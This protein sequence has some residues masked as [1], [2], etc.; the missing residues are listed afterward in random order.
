M[1]TITMVTHSPSQPG[2]WAV[3][4]CGRTAEERRLPPPGGPA[5]PWREGRWC[6]SH[7]WGTLREG[8]ERERE[9]GYARLWFVE[10]LGTCGDTL[11]WLLFTG[12]FYWRFSDYYHV[13]GI[14]FCYFHSWVR[15]PK[16]QLYCWED[17]KLERLRVQNFAFLCQSANIQNICTH[18]N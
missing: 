7:P 1:I 17:Y 8:G 3:L 15:W 13:V 6:P 5:A 10:E 9:E 14:K 16:I 11:R 4:W 2:R 18:K 12:T